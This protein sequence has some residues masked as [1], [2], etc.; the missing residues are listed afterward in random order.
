MNTEYVLAV[1]LICVVVPIVGVV[2]SYLLYTILWITSQ[3]RIYLHLKKR[4]PSLV[5]P[6]DARLTNSYRTSN[7][8]F[9]LYLYGL[10]SCGDPTLVALRRQ[11]LRREIVLLGL[12]RVLLGIVFLIVSATLV[13]ITWLRCGAYRL[14]VIVPVV[15]FTG[16]L[17]A[18]LN[19]SISRNVKV[20]KIAQQWCVRCS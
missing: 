2:V 20:N 7:Y 19:G 13:F 1:V 14:W 3:R 4:K 16:W 12:S 15:A 11:Y 5:W 10:G 8:V 6:A 9:A 18:K 17:Y